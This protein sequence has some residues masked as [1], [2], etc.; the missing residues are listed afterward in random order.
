M[1]N[2]NDTE[3]VE[4]TCKE[5]SKITEIGARIHWRPNG[6]LNPFEPATDIAVVIG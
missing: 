6:K 2:T 1:I 3:N 5:A 4:L